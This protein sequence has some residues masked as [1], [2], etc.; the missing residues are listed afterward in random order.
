M[1]IIDWIGNLFKNRQ[2]RKETRIITQ[3]I[4]LLE[5]EAEEITRLRNLLI[6]INAASDPQQRLNIYLR[7]ERELKRFEQYRSIIENLN[8]KSLRGTIF[9][10]LKK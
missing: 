1:G 9:S 3:M 7:F 10:N 4:S 2:L 5:G 6:Q 8:E